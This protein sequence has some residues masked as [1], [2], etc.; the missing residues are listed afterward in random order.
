MKMKH[1][2]GPWSVWNYGESAIDV[3]VGPIKGGV[4]VAQI[5][6]TDAHGIATP[7]AMS[8]GEANAALIASAPALLAQRDKLREALQA[9]LK[10]WNSR[11]GD[12]RNTHPASIQARAALAE[13][14]RSGV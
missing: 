1:T 13:T 6:C 10:D 14:E 11:T 3:A 4:A 8:A 9:L 2:P 7:D 5:V 12:Y